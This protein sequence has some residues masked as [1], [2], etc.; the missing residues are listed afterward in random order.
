MIRFAIVAFLLAVVYGIS[1]AQEEGRGV[2]ELLPGQGQTKSPVPAR[3]ATVFYPVQEA[4]IESG[5]IDLHNLPTAL[6]LIFPKGAS[7]S[8]DE[9]TR[10][11][12]L[13]NTEENHQFLQSWLDLVNDAPGNLLHKA[14]NLSHEIVKSLREHDETVTRALIEETLERFRVLMKY[15]PEFEPEKVGRY[16]VQTLE[17]VRMAEQGM[18]Q[19]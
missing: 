2:F 19:P 15:H 18:K 13:T 9:K 14:S 1:P 5:T 4:L 17:F 3:F 6:D 7:F 16:F 11:I 8:F 12:R 10:I